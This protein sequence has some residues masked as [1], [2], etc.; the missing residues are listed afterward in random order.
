MHQLRRQRLAREERSRSWLTAWAF[1][2]A[3]PGEPV[4]TP[5]P[6]R[7]R[8]PLGQDVSANHARERKRAHFGNV[9]YCASVS[10][11]PTCSSLVR[12]A[13][14]E[15]VAVAVE[16]NQAAAV[17]LVDVPEETAFGS[18][19][20][21]TVT[22]RHGQQDSLGDLLSLLSKS[23]QRT[24]NGSP[25][26]RWK[27]RLG[28]QG[29]VRALEVT[30]GRHGWHPHYH[31]L[32][33]LDRQ[34]TQD[35]LDA[36]G[37]W[38]ESRWAQMVVKVGGASHRPSREHGVD[39]RFADRHAVDYLAKL[40]DD[41]DVQGTASELARGDFKSGRKDSRL[42][43][44]F[45][46]GR[47][48]DDFAHWV[49]YTVA[50]KYKRVIFWSPG[51]AARYL[52][53]DQE[54]AT[55]E[56]L[57]EEQLQGS[58]LAFWIPAV[59]YRSRIMKSPGLAARVLELVESGEVEAA[60]DM[61]GGWFEGDERDDELAEFL[62][63]VDDD[64]VVHDPE[65][66]AAPQRWDDGF[67]ARTRA[68]MEAE[69]VPMSAAAL[70]RAEREREELERMADRVRE[71]RARR[72]GPPGS[73]PCGTVFTLWTWP[74]E[75]DWRLPE[76]VEWIE[77]DH[78]FFDERCRWFATCPDINREQA[79]AV[80]DMIGKP[81]PG[82]EERMAPLRDAVRRIDPQLLASVHPVHF[83]NLLHKGVARFEVVEDDP[84]WPCNGF[85]VQAYDA[86]G[87]RLWPGTC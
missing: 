42:P 73:E 31:Y 72:P 2:H 13:Q 16:R 86:D 15:R 79:R 28:V 46:D 87:R 32:I 66:V 61:V 64:G 29:Y 45:L 67:G 47:R 21:V 1:Q 17:P 54:D 63:R 60:A 76:V 27:E 74:K 7:C 82:F 78:T 49:E 9:E 25:Y 34:I 18:L 85:E 75:K 10:A 70:A 68:A 58:D 23:W 22:V 44:E 8:T 71:W 35:M 37:S 20:M 11:C 5:R 6:G 39:W 33:F 65:P 4:I 52:G 81:E 80:L 12:A 69:G 24:I 26:R 50:T 62:A 30:H 84:R 36:F 57:L 83:F 40:Q 19:L 56:E 14:R 55:D 51:L 3:V 53:A 38:L 77:Y 41:T 43:F 59:V 48:P